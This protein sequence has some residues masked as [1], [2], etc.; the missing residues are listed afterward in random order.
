M[1]VVNSNSPSFCHHRST[2]KLSSNVVCYWLK[3][4]LT[5]VCAVHLKFS[6]NYPEM[7]GCWQHLLA[8]QWRL[9]DHMLKPSDSI[10]SVLS[11]FNVASLL[12]YNHTV[13]F[14]I[15]ILILTWKIYHFSL[16]NQ[17]LW[18]HHQ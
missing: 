12:D 3:M 1:T 16:K 4:I 2:S 6:R 18:A 8:H 14:S 10:Q 11:T 7:L 17:H 13:V 15:S 5:S 9:H